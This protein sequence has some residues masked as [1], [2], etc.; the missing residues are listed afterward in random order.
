TTP[1]EPAPS[2]PAHD[3]SEATDHAG[4]DGAASAPAP[5]PVRLDE[6]G[7]RIMK[8]EPTVLAFR[9]VTVDQV[10]PF[11]VEST[12]KVV[13]P[14]RDVLGRP[15]TIINDQ[16]IPREK[17]LD[18][19]FFALQQ[20]NVA[21]VETPDLIILRDLAE[22]DR[23]DVPVVGPGESVLTRTDLG[24]IVEKVFELRSG[25]AANVGEMLKGVVPNFA[26]LNV[27]ADSNQI[28]VMGNIGLLQRLERL[29]TALDQPNAASLVTETFHL[30][31]ADA[32]AVATNIRDLFS[33]QG[34]T[35]GGNRAQEFAR[36]F[37]RG[38]D[39]NNNNRNARNNSSATTS[40]NLRVTAN[41]QQ[42]SVTVLAERP[43]LDQIRD[44][45]MMAWDKPLPEEAVVPRIYDLKNSDPIKIKDLLTGLFGRAAGQAGQNAANTQGTGRLAGQFS[46]EAIPE[47][48]QLVVVGKS[49]DNMAV[50]DKIIND[51][52]RPQTSG[53]PRIVE[54]KHASAEELADQLNALL[55]Q[56]GTLASIP[57]QESGLSQSDS[58]VSPFATQTTQGA[59][60][61][62]NNAQSNTSPGNIQFWWQRARPPTTT[63]G[64]SN[65][66]SKARIVPV[67]RQN[68]LLILAPAEYQE[69]LVELVTS[70]DKPGRQVL[71]SAVI[72]EI[73]LDDL[74]ALGLRWSSQGITPTNADNS[75]SLGAGTG[76]NQETFSGQ[77]NNLL[78]GLFDT[79]VL[80]VGVN[81]NLV[82][83]ALSEKTKVNILSEPRIFTSDNQEAEF[84]SGQDIPFIDES[85]TTD[86]G[87]LN[88]TF[89]Y[90][91]VGI[92][93]RARPRITINKD[94][95]L[96]IN[97]ELS[98]IQPNQTLFGGFIVDRRETTTH[99]IVR[100]GQ[101]VVVSGILRSEDSDIK[102]KVPLLGDI[103][104]LGA[105]FTSTEKTKTRTEL[106][107]FVTPIVIENPED[108]A[109]KTK[110]DAA[111]L[112]QLRREMGP[113][114]LINVPPVTPDA[115]PAPAG[116]AAQDKAPPEPAPPPQDP[117]FTP[118]DPG[119]TTPASPASPTH[120]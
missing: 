11:I 118:A 5:E 108:A 19:V 75:V 17:A 28:V 48:N 102:R 76:P 96:R 34:N 93:L 58:S 14:Q 23:Q 40:Q 90:R 71:L 9:N 29:I 117:A 39:Q 70:L 46:F 66:V 6:R 65:L 94:V 116:P 1:S 41:T 10:V 110:E 104:L 26:K 119:S 100:D 68:A 107:A 112:E 38:G 106:V 84:F 82:F 49:P 25:S 4:A 120:P 111:R 50:I 35:Q 15:I 98:S 16:P 60:N 32:T 73:N 3:E 86:N 64:S 53:L 51:I 83:Q 114:S 72:A 92:S 74:T 109:K 59:T 85:Q 78:P 2:A 80:D 77:K 81:L 33:Q 97:L 31:Y 56:E 45:I 101:T 7:R 52:D 95:D 12:G 37:G 87:T 115:S 79:S 24:T 36:I 13:L 67:W 21:V 62:Q 88:Q 113:D 18:L 42:N 20:A 103:P 91:A 63:A 43:V 89:D 105:I 54:L 99:L 47:K 22:I 44:Q 8:D 61:N 69:S 57:R 55:S 30:R 27:D